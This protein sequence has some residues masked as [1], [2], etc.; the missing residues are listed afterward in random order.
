MTRNCS[1]LIVTSTAL[2]PVIHHLFRIAEGLAPRW[3]VF[4]G[5]AMRA[6]P[7]NRLQWLANYIKVVIRAVALP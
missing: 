3:R 7:W 5:V 6:F 1:W 4:G 2:L